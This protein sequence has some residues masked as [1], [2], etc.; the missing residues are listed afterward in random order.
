MLDT[1]L[2]F[3]E[4]HFQKMIS[5]EGLNHFPPNNAKTRLIKKWVDYRVVSDLEQV[6]E[7]DYLIYVPYVKEQLMY[8]KTCI[9]ALSIIQKLSIESNIR[10]YVKD[11]NIKKN[12]YWIEISHSKLLYLV[13]TFIWSRS[14]DTSRSNIRQT[15]GFWKVVMQENV[16]NIME[17]TQN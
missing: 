3:S 12:Q 6:H 5:R 7:R 15:K 13:N 17:R 10:E 16:K 9:Y 1:C 8:Q 4:K 11:S 2:W 14:T